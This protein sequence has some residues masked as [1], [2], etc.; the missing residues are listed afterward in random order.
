MTPVDIATR[1]TTTGAA[2]APVA[3][4]APNTCATCH[5]LIGWN[6]A[7]DPIHAVSKP[8]T[9]CG[10]QV[11]PFVIAC[12]PCID[13][14]ATR[15]A[16]EAQARMAD[17][18]VAPV[19][20]PDPEPRK[21]SDG[22]NQVDVAARAR[23]Q[24]ATAYIKDYQG[25]F[26]LVLDLRAHPR[27]GTKW[28]SLTERQVDAVLASKAREAAWRAQAQSVERPIGVDGLKIENLPHRPGPF[29]GR[30]R[31]WRPDIHP[32]PPDRS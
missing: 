22:Y 2:H 21:A 18:V 28:F 13:A 31:G 12:D 23:E 4:V 5:G 17:F 27:F 16:E 11:P 20:T 30:E 10:M 7:V 14:L 1:F 32:V 29:R 3:S 24:E 6:A 8:C 25:R 9:F 15:R 26:G 19:A